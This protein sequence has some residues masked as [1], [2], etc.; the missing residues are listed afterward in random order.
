M[1]NINGKVYALN[2]ITPM[3]PWKT[4]LL[5]G[6]F[7]LLGWIK[8]LQKDLID[9][10]FIEF[11]RW[12]ILPRRQFPFLGDGQAKEDLKY[13]YLLFFSNFNGTWNQYIDAFSAVLSKGLNL[14]WRWSEKFPGS[15]PV[16]PFKQYIAQV[17]FDTDYYF[18]AYPQAAANDVK[19]A[20]VVQT[21]LDKLALGAGGL[22]PQQFAEAYQRFVIEVQAHLGETGEAP[23]PF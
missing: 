23:V 6:F 12:V 14:I 10:S 1:S 7:L 11:A 18:T 21:S 17:Q 15:V 2:V 13:D 4:W 8:P 19:S 3:K 20:H 9:L 16:T 5:R 22:T